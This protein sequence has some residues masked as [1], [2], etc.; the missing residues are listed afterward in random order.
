LQFLRVPEHKPPK[1]P[2]NRGGTAVASCLGHD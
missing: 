2:M 1:T